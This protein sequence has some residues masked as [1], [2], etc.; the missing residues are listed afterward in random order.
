MYL[1]INGGAIRDYAGNEGKRDNQTIGPVGEFEKFVVTDSNAPEIVIGDVTSGGSSDDDK[2]VD[3]TTWFDL[4]KKSSGY[5]R[6]YNN[7]GTYWTSD[8]LVSNTDGY[9]N[10]ENY[11]ETKNT[12]IKF[13]NKMTFAITFIIVIDIIKLAMSMF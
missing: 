11:D 5:L 7:D 6:G 12:G 10:I 2:V 9:V 13:Y 3:N 4:A 8:S 1:S